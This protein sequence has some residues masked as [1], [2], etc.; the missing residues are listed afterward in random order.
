MLTLAATN[1]N[2]LLGKPFIWWLIT[3]RSCFG[4]IGL[5]TFTKH[6]TIDQRSERN[7]CILPTGSVPMISSR[8]GCRPLICHLGLLI[9]APEQLHISFAHRISVVGA[10]WRFPGTAQ[11]C[12]GQANKRDHVLLAFYSTLSPPFFISPAAVP[13][14]LPLSGALIKCRHCAVSTLSHTSTAATLC[15]RSLLVFLF[16]G[17]S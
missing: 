1:K 14:H 12:S 2:K 11:G 3:K 16:T 9:T 7:C 8:S 5:Y 6:N 13:C 4:F 10:V 15:T 17:V